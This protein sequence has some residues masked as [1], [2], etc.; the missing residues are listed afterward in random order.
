[1]TVLAA[2]V[3]ALLLPPVLFDLFRRPTVRRLALRNI[4]RRKGEASL[5]VLGSL[6]ATALITASFVVGDSFDS[7]I[8]AI[9]RDFWGPTDEVV[10]A[11]DPAQAAEIASALAPLTHGTDPVLDGV[12]PVTVL[13]VAMSDGGAPSTRMGDASVRLIETDLN[14]APSFGGSPGDTGLESIGPVAFD[15]IVLN[16]RLADRLQAQAGDE[17]LVHVGGRPLSFT[18]DSVVDRTGLAGFGEALVGPGAVSVAASVAEVDASVLVSNTGGVF[19]GAG[20]TSDATAAIRGVVGPT[21]DISPVKQEILRDAELEGA[22]MASMFG[23]IGGFSVLAGILL[24]VNLFVMLAE[25]RTSELGTMRALGLRRHQVLRSF[26]LEGAAY[27]LAA[28]VIGVV[29]GTGVGQVLIM[30]SGRALADEPDLTLKLALQPRS[31]LSAAIIGL[32]ISQL[33]VFLTSWRISRLDVIRAMRE[34]P[35]PPGGLR[36]RRSLVFGV[37]GIAAGAALFV[38][39]PDEPM[40]A[41]A[42]PSI[43]ALATIPLLGRILPR[44]PAVIGPALLVLGWCVAVFSRPVMDQPPIEAFLV[45]GALLVGAA[46][47]IAGQ[48][49]RLWARIGER[50]P[51]GGMSGRLAMAYPLARATRTGLLLAMYALVIFTVTFMSVFNSVFQAQVPAFAANVGGSYD[52]LVDSNATAPLTPT[53][54]ADDRIEGTVVV[55][56]QVVRLALPGES[57]PDRWRWTSAIDA[58]ADPAA[59]PPLEERAGEFADDTAAWAAVAAGDPVVI[60]DDD[61]FFEEGDVGVGSVVRVLDESGQAR[62][63]TIIGATQQGWMVDAGVWVSAETLDGLSYADRGT[64]LYLDAAEGVDV[65]ALSGEIEGR[66]LEQGAEALGFVEAAR[67]EVDEQEAFLSLLRGFLGLGLVIGIAGLGVVLVRA[68]RERRRQIGMLRAV[69]IQ[70]TQIRRAFVSEAAFIGIQ[71][72]A[73]GV[74][75]GLLSSWQVLTQSTSIESGLDFVV[76]WFSLAVIVGV[77]FGAS[78]VAALGPALRAGRIMPAAALRVA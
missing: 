23:T 15:A 52:L 2:I 24:L 14:I 25:E 78:L 11:D 76:P 7:S 77:A 68:V 67:L 59:L 28:A 17:V 37:L 19:A 34:L 22:E 60:I 38:A 57:D 72:V 4:R 74:G 62:P 70:S 12:L 64:R 56:R 58:T 18:V 49:D 8:G 35:A 41:L 21:V 39:F 71:G 65:A 16:D 6:L 55:E 31:L 61:T 40:A 44:R 73:L 27:G 9:G 66:W 51:G 29:L 48:A 63:V 50:L 13:R 45:Q 3:L 33:T 36:R 26:S 5:V 43:V 10:S 46:V 54:L 47:L 30:A 42:G 32:G 20:I 75:L 53:D 1:M 69:G